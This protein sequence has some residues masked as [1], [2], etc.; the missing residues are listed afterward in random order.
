MTLPNSATNFVIF[1][2]VSLET[3][4]LLLFRGLWACALFQTRAS[5][6]LPKMSWGCRHGK[7]EMDSSDVVVD[8]DGK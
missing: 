3:A 4:R 2:E 5:P 7:P 1:H 8:L 6:V